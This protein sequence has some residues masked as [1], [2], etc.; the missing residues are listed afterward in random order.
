MRTRDRV[1]ARRLAVQHL[2]SP[3]APDVATAVRGLVAVQAQEHAISRYS[4]GLRTG[5]DEKEVLRQLDAGAVVRTHVLRPTWHYVAAEDLRWL[6]D[7]TSAKV[8]S[9]LAGRHR[10][11]GLTPQVQTHAERVLV[12]ALEG[13]VPATRRDLATRFAADGLPSGVEQVGHLVMLAEL[14]GLVCSGPVRGRHHTYALVDDVVPSAPARDR[15]AAVRELVLRFFAGHGPGS[16]RDLVRWTTLTLAEVRPV[17]DDLGGE[18]LL[19]RVDLDGRTLWGPP[20]VP[21]ARRGA[22]R[23]LLLPTF[24]EAYL[25]W[26]ATPPVRM[27]GHPR[28]DDPITYFEP[29]TGIV[30]CDRQDVGWWV[31]KESGRRM[32]VTLHLG[33]GL[34]EERRAS[35]E[36]AAGHLAAFTGRRLE[37]QL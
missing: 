16:D 11:L 28:G 18:G 10:A 24:D 8:I 21:R 17:L 20:E 33:A 25:T 4:L 34:D 36:E 12:S 22:P 15:D 7:L 29:G 30:L 31:R 26:P 37:L 9:A 6:L 1:H 19:E 13:G 32:T 27:A 35:I 3:P 2:T 5:L 14:R 23:A